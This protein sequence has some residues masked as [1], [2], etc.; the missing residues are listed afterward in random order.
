MH[1]G[2]HLGAHRTLA[3][4]F[5]ALVLGKN[6]DDARY[7]AAYGARPEQV[8]ISAGLEDEA[9]LVAAVELALDKAAEAYR[10]GAGV[11]GAAG[12]AIPGA[13]GKAKSEA[14]VKVAAEETSANF[15]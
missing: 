5:N 15:E 1:C 3:L 4:P 12:Q 2:P 14:D 9:E 6:P 13:D 8:R 11:E 7:H 10:T